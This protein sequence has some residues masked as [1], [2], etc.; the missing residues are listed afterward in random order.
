MRL[1]S[2]VAAIAL[3]IALS[4]WFLHAWWQ[5][6][7]LGDEARALALPACTERLGSEDACRD[8]LATYHDECARLTFHGGGQR[9]LNPGPA[10]IDH[11]AYLECVVLGVDAWVAEN[12]RALERGEA[13]RAKRYR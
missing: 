1:R 8:H 6:R 7:A 4:A 12:G 3:A 9:S 13:E 11:A 5:R 2:V 10:R